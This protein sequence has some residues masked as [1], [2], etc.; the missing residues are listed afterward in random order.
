[1]FRDSRVTITPEEDKSYQS[2]PERLLFCAVINSALNDARMAPADKSL[3]AREAM[4]FLLTTRSD[5]YL[6]LLEFKPVAFRQGLVRTQHLECTRP[7]DYFGEKKEGRMASIESE[8]KKRRVF[9]YNYKLLKS[10]MFNTP[11]PFN[12]I[13]ET[14]PL[15]TR[16]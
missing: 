4:D 6:E 1:M 11:I 16:R 10:Q 14:S 13:Y 9:R 3:I 15:V 2:P 8:N 7:L 5:L 12:M